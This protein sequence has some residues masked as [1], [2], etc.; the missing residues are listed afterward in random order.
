MATALTTTLLFDGSSDTLT[1]SGVFEIFPE[2]PAT[3]AITGTGTY[4]LKAVVG[5]ASTPVKD[6]LPET[7]ALGE[8]TFSVANIPTR[9]VKATGKFVLS[10]TGHA[11][12][13]TAS[14]TS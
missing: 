5:N 8:I 6:V 14:V 4:T 12:T 13:D 7:D 3:I 10:R 1:E 9:I 2:R 11:A